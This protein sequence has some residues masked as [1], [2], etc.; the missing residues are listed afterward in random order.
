MTAPST[1]T[2]ARSDAGYVVFLEG[3]ATMN[4]GPAF[5]TFVTQLLDHAEEPALVVCADG[6]EYMDSTFLGG[7]ISLHKKYSLTGRPRFIVAASRESRN[8]LLVS[9]RLDLILKLTDRAP[10][11]SGNRSPIP[12][13]PANSR[14]FTQHAIECHRLLAEIG[15]PQAAVFQLVADQLSKELADEDQPE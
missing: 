1:L 7:L 8:R 6:C 3:R 14:D 2:V 12:T 5:H 9:A 15:G 11:C 4:E 13:P 10:E